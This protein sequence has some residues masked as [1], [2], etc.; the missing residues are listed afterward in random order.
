V[1]KTRLL[2]RRGGALGVV[3]AAAVLGTVAPGCAGRGEKFRPA[4]AQEGEAVIYVFRLGGPLMGG[5]VDVV[6]D[7]E[8][9]LP[10]ARGEY[11]A[12]GVQPGEHLI[13]VEGGS[14]AV[15]RVVL[16]AGESVFVELVTQTLGGKPDLEVRQEEEGRLLIEGTRE[17]AAAQ[18]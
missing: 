1:A 11:F 12:Y 8:P 2:V 6:I 3:L 4:F 9:V 7:Q 5:P 17:A 13:R 10:L 14:S 18:R 15:A 16:Q